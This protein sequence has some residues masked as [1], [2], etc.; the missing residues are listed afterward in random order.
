MVGN[1]NFVTMRKK[2]E[3]QSFYINSREIYDNI[4]AEGLLLV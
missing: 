1:V 2:N 3:M 4:V